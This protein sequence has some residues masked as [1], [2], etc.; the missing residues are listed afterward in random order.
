MI[1]LSLTSCGGEKKLHL[2]AKEGEPANGFVWENNY[3]VIT[4]TGYTGSDNKLVVPETINKKNV[5]TI[6]EGAFSGFSGM[7][8]VVLPKTLTSIESNAFKDCAMLKTVEW[9]AVECTFPE[10]A[11]GD[12]ESSEGAGNP[13]FANC[14]ALETVKFGKGVKSIPGYAFQG[15]SGLK[16]IHLND[17]LESIGFSAF[18]N[19]DL[20]D[21]KIPST[22]KSIGGVAFLSAVTGD[23]IELTL[24]AA[25]EDMLGNPFAGC[26]I[27]HI[28]MGGE[29]E[30]F[31][32]EG[33]CLIDKEYGS[34]YIG[35]SNSQIPA[36]GSIR[37]IA[38]LACFGVK[39]LGTLDLPD[40]ITSIGICAFEFSELEKITLPAGIAKIEDET[41][42]GCSKLTNVTFKGAVGSIGK[43]AFSDCSSLKN[44]VF[45]NKSGG[46]F[47]GEVMLDDGAFQNCSSLTSFDMKITTVPNF[48]FQGC[49]SLE[50]VSLGTLCN[51]IG[52]FAFDGC[53]KLHITLKDFTH[54][55]GWYAFRNC[56]DVDFDSYYDWY[57]TS[58]DGYKKKY[59]GYW[60]DGNTFQ[61][62]DDYKWTIS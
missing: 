48:V 58:T 5:T 39:G 25:L 1:V 23:A 11:S 47:D 57:M 2:T 26:N 28:R 46:V 50:K 45:Q 12:D 27:S 10:E 20:S 44:V 21:I 18:G 4:I 13:V 37:S 9:N 6:A 22:V 34:V 62:Y 24:P 60:V 51:E 16:T 52:N 56:G 8:S 14:D 54:T 15:C 33:D 40:S 38:P 55:V 49:S 59:T 32:A 3:D 61:V 19:T 53:R 17:G 42:N 31:Y 7:E 29:N 41:F 36:D 30:K 35:C 43:S